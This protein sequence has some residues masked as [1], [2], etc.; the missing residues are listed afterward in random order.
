MDGAIFGYRI[1]KM[2]FKM[3]EKRWNQL[4]KPDFVGDGDS[5]DD[6]DI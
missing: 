5:E 3:Y 2:V 1:C 4:S 6:E